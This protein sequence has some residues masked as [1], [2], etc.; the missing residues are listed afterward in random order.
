MAVRFNVTKPRFDLISGWA[1]K[2]LAAVLTYGLKK[3]GAHNWRKGLSQG[4]T[5][6][7]AL[8]HI[9]RRCDGE[10]NDQ[11][12]GLPH[13]AHAMANLMFALEQEALGTGTHDLYIPT[14]SL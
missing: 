10:L 5:L 2:A 12:S 8:H 9:M 14:K 1:M 3:Y 11:E 6:S 7:S 4:E 13:L